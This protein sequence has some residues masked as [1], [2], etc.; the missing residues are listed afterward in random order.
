MLIIFDTETTGKADWNNQDDP[1]KQPHV[2]QIA[3]VVINLHGDI[4]GK[5]SFLIAPPDGVAMEPAAEK[6]HGISLQHARTYGLP[7]K[8]VMPLMFNLFKRCTYR[9]AYNID[10]DD[11]MIRTETLRLGYAPMSNIPFG[12]SIAQCVMGMCCPILKM[13]K[14]WIDEADPYKW[15]SL[16]E[17]HHHFFERDIPN[18]HDALGDV[19]AT[20]AVLNMVADYQMTNESSVP[21]PDRIRAVLVPPGSPKGDTRTQAR[22]APAE[23]PV[24]TPASAIPPPVGTENQPPPPVASSEP[25]V[26][27]DG[28]PQ[29]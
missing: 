29:F 24:F 4:K 25:T 26:S 13:P 15:P 6:I 5:F 14:A 10:F 28:S 12:G 3:A 7:A 11:L 1:T 18:A 8:V 9:V 19:L 16:T 17:A 2:I 27:F 21:L 20:L 23:T 22:S